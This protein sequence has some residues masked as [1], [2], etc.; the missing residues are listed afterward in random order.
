[1]CAHAW[2]SMHRLTGYPSEVCSLLPVCPWNWTQAVG[3]G[4]KC[5][6]PL[7]ICLNACWLTWLISFFLS[8]CFFMW[9]LL[10]LLLFWRPG[11]FVC[12]PFLRF[13][14]SCVYEWVWECGYQKKMPDVPELELQWVESHPQWVL[15]TEH[16][17][18]GRAGSALNV[19]LVI[20]SPWVSISDR[21]TVVSRK[22][23]G[24]F[25]FFGWRVWRC[26]EARRSVNY[27][28]GQRLGGVFE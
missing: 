10:L 13:T 11:G 21:I 19:E 22:L 25:F 27:C 17:S 4:C 18:S 26:P 7:W 24:Y 20:S 2:R 8:L 1:M 28:S 5:L 15:G 6:F 3:S 14:H 12:F 23:H 16:V 9:F